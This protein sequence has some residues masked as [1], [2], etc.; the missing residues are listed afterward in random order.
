MLDEDSVKRLAI[1]PL[2]ILDSKNPD[3]QNVI[4]HAP[5]LL[6]F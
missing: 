6:D 5:R 4:E 3:L 1:N 2:R